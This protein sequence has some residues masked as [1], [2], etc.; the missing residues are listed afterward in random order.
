[1]AADELESVLYSLVGVFDGDELVDEFSHALQCARNAELAGA[2]GELVVAALFHDVARSPLVGPTYPGVAHEVAG[3]S[4]L[5]PRFGDRVAWLVGAHTVAKVY[6]MDTE[7]GYR[8][9]LSP[10]SK[11]SALAQRATS[12]AGFVGHRWWPDA[13]RLR[14]FDDAAKDPNAILPEPGALL[15]I[16][17]TLRLD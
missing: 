16:V 5:E 11:R 6:L 17:R 1:M 4:W 13:L 8:G 7:P 10:E 9:S 3:A 12:R 15:E 2:D 14:R